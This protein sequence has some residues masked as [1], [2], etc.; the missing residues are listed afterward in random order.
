M[1][2]GLFSHRISKMPMTFFCRM[3]SELKEG[4]KVLKKLLY[5]DYS[6]HF[7]DVV[8]Y[9]VNYSVRLL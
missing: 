4:G 5:L 1:L 6:L 8:A 7:K 3:V 9:F 2:T